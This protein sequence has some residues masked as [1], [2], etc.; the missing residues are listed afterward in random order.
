MSKRLS[1][2]QVFLVLELL[3]VFFESN[4]EENE[5]LL[6]KFSQ[7]T[8]DELAELHSEMKESVEHQMKS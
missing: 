5:E 1:T 6:N 8:I 7:S 4:P 3:D 2:N